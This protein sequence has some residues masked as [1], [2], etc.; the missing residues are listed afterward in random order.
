M[1]GKVIVVTPEEYAEEFEAAPDTADAGD[2]AAPKT[3]LSR[4]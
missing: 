1:A 4:R 2:A 3:T